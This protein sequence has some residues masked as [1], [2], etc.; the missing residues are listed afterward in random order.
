VSRARRSLLAAAALLLLA[1]EA[2][3]APAC[4]VELVLR[5]LPSG[6]EL[7]R[8]GTDDAGGFALAFRHSV[9]LRTVVD[10]YRIED[11]TIVQVEQLFDTHGPGLP[12]VAAPGL[13]FAR[14]GD[15]FR[16]R[17]HRPIDRLVLRPTA[18]SENRLLAAG[19][20]ELWRLGAP[21][22]E[23]GPAPCPAPRLA[24]EVR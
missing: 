15:R 18:A 3:A 16:V 17:M 5:A 2:R 20:I 19:A 9:T 11:G 10:R 12:D 7:A 4:P 21:V 13:A 6:A 14:D 1:T 22:L 24:T 8:V 23:L